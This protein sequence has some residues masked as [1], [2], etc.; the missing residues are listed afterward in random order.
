MTGH[1][2][3]IG[4]R[5]EGSGNN[6][7]KA[8]FGLEGFDPALKNFQVG[9]TQFQFD[10]GQKARFLAIAVEQQELRLGP[11][12]G[13]ND[14]RHATAATDVEPTL[15]LDERQDAEA[16]EQMPADH[17]IRVTYRG[18]IVGLVPLLQQGQV[19]E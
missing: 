13:Q 10:L 9:Q 1:L 16:V 17:L 14:A 19:V 15:A 18:Q 7:I 3:K 6:T 8:G 4:K 12:D 5:T 2:G 11:H